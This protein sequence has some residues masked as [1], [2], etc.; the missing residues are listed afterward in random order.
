MY[1]YLYNLNIT[2]DHVHINFWCTHVSQR[3]T[4]N[5]YTQPPITHNNC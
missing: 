3:P 1:I 4:L 2:D 5:T